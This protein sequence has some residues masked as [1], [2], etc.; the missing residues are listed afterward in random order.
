MRRRLL[1]QLQPVLAQQAALRRALHSR[2]LHSP[3][4][5]AAASAS[6][7]APAAHSPS[8]TPSLLPRS[9]GSL[10]PASAAAA[11]AAA[12]TDTARNAG[13]LDEPLSL[14]LSRASGCFA[15]S[16]STLLHGVAAPWAH[17][18]T[19]PADDMVFM[20][21]GANVA[22]YGFWRL[23]DPNF[24]LGPSVQVWLDTYT[25]GRL[26]TLL[27]SALSHVDLRFMADHFM[28]SLDNFKSLR[29]HTLI[30]CAFSHKDANHL[31]HNMIGLYF[32]GSSIAR[33]FGPDFLLKLY[34]QGALLGSAFY[35]T[36]MAFLAPQKQ[37]FG[38]WNTPALGASAAVNATVLLYI[39]L[40]PTNILYLHFLIPL[41]AA[42][43]GA[44][45][46]GAD[47]RRVKKGNSRVAGSAHLG[48]A[49]VAALVFAEMKG[50]I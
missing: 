33:T 22:V 35:L 47:L 39:F 5:L 36:E 28:I 32:F 30:T 25:G 9:T 6:P 11:V 10:L 7:P 40:Y 16:S 12:R 29:L 17:W 26:H 44:Y 34:V 20:L 45:L 37:G 2:R 38:G 50:W 23:A 43:V 3:F 21:A 41:P 4:P 18:T 14:Q 19:T 15:S 27:T 31:F 24:G 8:P 49:V 42:L 1:Q 46:I 48:G 13:S